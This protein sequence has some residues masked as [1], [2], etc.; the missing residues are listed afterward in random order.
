MNI[1]KGNSWLL[2]A[3]AMLAGGCTSLDME[4]GERYH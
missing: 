4:P 1:K 2:S 3:S